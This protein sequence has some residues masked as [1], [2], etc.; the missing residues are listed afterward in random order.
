MRWHFKGTILK[1]AR[2]RL[3]ILYI[4]NSSG[5]S[6][7]MKYSSR[8]KLNF[9]FFLN[10]YKEKFSLFKWYIT[11]YTCTYSR[12]SPVIWIPNTWSVYSRIKNLEA[13]HA[14]TFPG[15][16]CTKA[17]SSRYLSKTWKTRMIFKHLQYFLNNNNDDDLWRKQKLSITIFNLV[18]RHRSHGSSLRSRFP[19][20]LLFA[21]TEVAAR[22]RFTQYVYYTP[23]CLKW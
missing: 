20:I 16:G 14:L 17:T 12:T 1:T 21:D 10:F 2:L 23:G 4:A 6:K 22:V 18:S 3:G 15:L 7:V 8:G 9:V 11:G 19:H 5:P 13:A